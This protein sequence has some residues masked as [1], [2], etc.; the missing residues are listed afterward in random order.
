MQRGSPCLPRPM[1][2][3]LANREDIYVVE[4]RGAPQAITK[5]IF[6]TSY[7][8]KSLQEHKWAWWM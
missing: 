7:Q 6:L 3:S 4:S 8:A 2:P 5:R 1:I